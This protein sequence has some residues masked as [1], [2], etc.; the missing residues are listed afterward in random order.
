MPDVKY[1]VLKL[2]KVDF[3]SPKYRFIP[4]SWDIASS[5]LEESGTNSNTSVKEIYV[6]WKYDEEGNIV[7]YTYDKN[8]GELIESHKCKNPGKI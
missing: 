7:Y 2:L 6:T 4:K 1:G 3:F 5:N 8:T